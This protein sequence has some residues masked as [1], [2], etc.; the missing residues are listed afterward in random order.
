MGSY[1][2]GA[3]GIAVSVAL[4]LAGYRQTI[5]ARKE[6]IA[7][8]NADLERVL[9]RR[10]ILEAFLPSRSDIDRLRDGKS[11]EYRVSLSDMLLP[12]ELMNTVYT[13]LVENDFISHDLR[14]KTIDEI[15]PLFERL[16]ISEEQ[17]PE[18]VEESFA[19]SALPILLAL[20]T[21][22]LGAIVA[23]LPQ[24]R[25][26][27]SNRKAVV[28]LVLVAGTSFAI[29][30]AYLLFHRLRDEE[31]ESL[32]RSS[33]LR[34][35]LEFEIN[36]F[37]AIKKTGLSVVRAPVQSGYD[38]QVTTKTGAKVLVEIKAWARR[39]PTMMIRQL[40]ERLAALV[41][42]E[43]ALEALIVVRE[44]LILPRDIIGDSPIRILS[45]RELRHY[46]T[47]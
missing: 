36:V 38:L 30:A 9:S 4:F 29:I 40:I 15:H 37:R 43:G 10:V 14:K 32:P 45:F 8:A 6:R 33:G 34:A 28:D 5:G 27:A 46:F 42:K 44:P 21:S 26:I 12:V 47:H 20:M 23:V 16:S 7:S 39:V 19:R 1:L 3:L 11:R 13:R 2:L 17:E 35:A 25:S 31:Q 41:A 24:L 22:L 18:R